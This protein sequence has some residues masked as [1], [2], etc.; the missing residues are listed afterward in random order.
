MGN[1]GFLPSTV[2]KI[3]RDCTRLSFAL[4]EEGFLGCVDG[5]HRLP[6][7]SGCRGLGFGV[8]RFRVEGGRFES[9][10]FLC[11]VYGLGFRLRVAL[12]GKPVSGHCFSGTTP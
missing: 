9:S 7:H 11:R 2:A 12:D 6:W 3:P 10:R 4:I 5:R 1:A 8:L